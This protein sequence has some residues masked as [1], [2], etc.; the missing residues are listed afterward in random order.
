MT[1]KICISNLLS[2]FSSVDFFSDVKVITRFAPSPTGLL[3]LGHAYAARWAY[4]IAH[5]HGGE[6]LLRFEDIDFTRVRD[7]YYQQI[8]D[9]LHWLGIAWM[10]EPW[11]QSAR[12]AASK[13]LPRVT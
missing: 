12:G 11:R 1:S 13:S 8:E 2:I 10:P 5:Q 6:M 7:E 9:D 3:H 4:D